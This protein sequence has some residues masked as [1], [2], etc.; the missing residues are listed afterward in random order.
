MTTT[1]S[2]RNK[3]MS[4]RAVAQPCGTIFF[5]L[6]LLPF[7][8]TYFHLWNSAAR[9]GLLQITT[10][11]KGGATTSHLYIPEGEKGYRPLKWKSVS[12]SSDWLSRITQWLP[13]SFSTEQ[14]QSIPVVSLWDVASLISFPQQ[15]AFERQEKSPPSLIFYHGDEKWCLGGD[16]KKSTRQLCRSTLLGRYLP[17]ET[18]TSIPQNGSTEATNELKF[19]VVK[20]FRLS[21]GSSS[22]GRKLSTEH[23]ER[24]AP[25]N[26]RS[27]LSPVRTLKGTFRRNPNKVV[28]QAENKALD[29][30]LRYPATWL[31]ILLNVGLALSYYRHGVSLDSVCK[32]YGKM[33]HDEPWRSWTGATAHF[34]PWHLGLNMMALYSVGEH[35]ES[36]IYSPIGFFLST[37]SIM[38]LTSVAWL[39]IETVR[40]ERARRRGSSYR[41][42]L[43]VGFS[44]VIFAWMTISTLHQTQTCPIP[45]TSDICFRTYRVFGFAVSLSPLISLVMAQILL[46]RVSFSGHLAGIVVGFLVEWGFLPLTRAQPAFLVPILFY[47]HLIYIRKLIAPFWKKIVFS[48]P[49]VMDSGDSTLTTRLFSWWRQQQPNEWRGWWLY[50]TAVVLCLSCFSFGAV[51]SLTMSF[52]LAFLFGY[53]FVCSSLEQPM[54]FGLTA[55]PSTSQNHV[56]DTLARGYIVVALLCVITAVMTLASWTLTKVESGSLFSSLILLLQILFLLMSICLVSGELVENEIGEGSTHTSC[57]CGSNH[58]NRHVAG[59]GGIFYVTL[60]HTLIYPSHRLKREVK[61]WCD[62]SYFAT[63]IFQRSSYAPLSL[64]DYSDRSFHTTSRNQT[65]QDARTRPDR[66]RRYIEQTGAASNT[67]SAMAFPSSPSLNQTVS[68]PSDETASAAHSQLD[69]LDLRAARLKA[70]DR[71]TV[72]NN[73]AQKR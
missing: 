36:G 4:A 10:Q 65:S 55:F 43:T 5:F 34:A 42:T 39:L 41:P 58:D 59:H 2:T 22:D 7:S 57:H 47:F 9:Q 23:D 17:T 30:L 19:A 60:G 24:D 52:A 28:S 56:G 38:S 6:V 72:P 66:T 3:L 53:H 64:V 37:V 18:R 27:E 8:L 51:Q 73:A 33:L 44:G 50:G 21:Y 12:D 61:S 49:Q 31:L 29:S 16:G 35:L 68:S 45:F 14:E 54:G 11:S 15:H 62:N 26:S 69:L 71:V 63:S 32:D 48:P 40:I 46:P 25:Q 13:F 70:L 20:S 67:A 1:S